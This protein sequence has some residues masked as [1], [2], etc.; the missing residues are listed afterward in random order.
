MDEKPG[1]LQ[2]YGPE[3][4]EQAVSAAFLSPEEIV[5]SKIPLGR[6][7]AWLLL[8]VMGVLWGATFS[9]AKIAADGGG[10]PLGI[11]YWQSLIGAV[12]L[13]TVII[14]TGR[15]LPLKPANIGFYVTCGLLGSVIPG[16]LFFYAASRVS[17]GVLSI[18]VATVPLLTFVAAAALGVE[19]FQFGRILGVL[20]GGLSI[21]LLVGPEESLPDPSAVPW[22]LAALLAAVCY[23]AENMVVALRM[24]SGISAVTVTGGLYLAATLI[25]TPLVILTGTFVPLAWPWG[26][27]E[28]ALVGM[29]II[30]VT[31]YSMFIFLITHAGP[32]FASQTAYVVTFSG[33]FWGVMIFDET[34]SAW[35]W[36]SLATMLLA[37]ALVRP[38]K[39]ERDL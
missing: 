10:H 14:V 35:I 26:A 27:V 36:A 31:A 37:L 2:G 17:P 32:V 33:V 11:N 25:M 20:F 1:V 28:W 29:A 21:F 15:K 38:R 18:T 4:A 8:L 34:H 16:V 7:R 6:A 30:S 39:V 3:I 23:S 5:E 24:P 22:V 9:L 19:K 12:I 13:S